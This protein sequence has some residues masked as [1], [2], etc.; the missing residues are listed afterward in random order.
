MEI[1]AVDVMAESGDEQNRQSTTKSV[2]RSAPA[3]GA[4]LGILKEIAEWSAA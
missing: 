2:S 1:I 4:I 3:A